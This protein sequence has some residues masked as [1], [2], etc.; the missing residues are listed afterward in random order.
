M[1]V[2]FTNTKDPMHRLVLK[3][4]RNVIIGMARSRTM[5]N[6][7]LRVMVHPLSVLLLVASISLVMASQLL[8]HIPIPPVS[9]SSL[10][11]TRKRVAIL[12][13]VSSFMV[14]VSGKEKKKMYNS[15]K[16]L[17][18][19]LPRHTWFDRDLSL[20]GR[21]MVEQEDGTYRHTLVKINR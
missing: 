20:A 19:A 14:V 17:F 16:G 12:K 3:R 10:S 2:I 21:V 7:T 18:H 8:V 13:L 15:R 11:L 9:R 1:D 5:E 6:T 4:S